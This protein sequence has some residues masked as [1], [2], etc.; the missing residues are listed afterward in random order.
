MHFDFSK[1]LDRGF[2]V[3]SFSKM[4][5]LQG[6]RIGWVLT[7][8]KNMKKLMPYFN[9]ATGAM[10]SFG[11]EIAKI[12]LQ[13]KLSFSE[14]YSQAALE[15]TQILNRYQ[16]D[17]IKPEGAFFVLIKY[18]KLGSIITNELSTLGVEVASGEAFGK[19]TE[20]YIRA[21]FAQDQYTIINAFQIIAEH[22]GYS[23][24]KLLQ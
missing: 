16:V 3:S 4:Y 10:S 23:H 21:S 9:N 19:Q 18:N 5:P 15:A 11:Q 7:S 14:A 12:F 13:K 8:A 6:A 17:F 2:I 1:Y 24:N 22:W 20:N